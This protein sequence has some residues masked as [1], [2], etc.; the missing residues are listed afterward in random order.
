[1]NAQ[2]IMDAS[3]TVTTQMDHITAIAIVDG[4]YQMMAKLARVYLV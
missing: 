2:A 4:Y 1:M 3:K